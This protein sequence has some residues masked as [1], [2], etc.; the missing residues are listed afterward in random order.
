MS[1][2]ILTG[3]TTTGTP[4]IGNYLGAIKPALNLSK[5]FDES[6]FFLADYHAIIKNSNSSEIQDSVKSVAQAWLAS[7]LDPEKSNF[8]RQS[9]VPEILEL[10]WILNCVT[11][12]GL[13]NR[14]HAYKAAT[15]LNETDEDKGITMGLFSYP[16][17]MA[18][19]I[20]MFNATHVP[21]GPDQIQHLEMTRDIAARFNHIYKNTFSMPE[22]I[23]QK[24]D[25]I[26]LGQDGRKMSKSYKNIIPLLST[27]KALKKS[28]AKIITNSLEPGE[29]KDYESC[30]VF[31]LYRH[32][33]NSD[34]QESL[35]EAYKE[36]ISWGDAKN[37]LFEKVNSHLSPIREKY[38]ELDAD[39]NLINELLLSGAKKVRPQAQELL[40]NVR[41]SIG[42][43]SIS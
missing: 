6:Y 28:I 38:F 1:K 11:A 10:S 13:M 39:V 20:L 12:K 22:A 32:F 14:S 24:A 25:E 43:K 4:H 29:P 8:Y 3:I 26:I 19:D 9:D 5:E 36:G 37:K 21:V 34:E 2:R 30:T 17:L 23:T 27:E 33:S 40:G 42:I 41:D 18:A 31:S 35:K 16:V 7:G 15:A